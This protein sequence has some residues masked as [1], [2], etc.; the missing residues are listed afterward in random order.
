M[1]IR[2]RCFA[3]YAKS[4]RITCPPGAEP[5]TKYCY[6]AGAT[7]QRAGACGR[8]VEGCL[9]PAAST[10]LKSSLENP[11]GVTF[12]S[13]PEACIFQGCGDPL[14]TNFD[15]KVTNNVKALCEYP[16]V[17]EVPG[18]TD[19]R[20]DNYDPESTFSTRTCRKMGCTLKDSPLY[21]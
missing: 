8:V 16:E 19:S 15:S 20:F 9:D 5:V 14:A 18:C 10:F 4:D 21:D 12:I 1:C 6:D 11:E 3:S 13:R 2:D 7:Y 17:A